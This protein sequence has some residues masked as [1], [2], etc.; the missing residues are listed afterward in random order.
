MVFPVPPDEGARL[1]A[2]RELS[3]L[4]TPPEEIYDDVVRLAA[5]I[6][7]TPFAIIN[8]VD[9][10]RQ[11]G[12]ALVG[13]ASSEAPRE[14]SFC[15]RTIVS[16]SGTLIV[17]DTHADPAWATN[18][19]VLGMPFLRF[20]AGASITDS[21]GHALGSVCVADQQPR[22]I[23]PEMVEALRILARQTAAHLQLRRNTMLL[24]QANDELRRHAT[25]DALT[26][27]ANRTLMHDRVAH[28]LATRLRTRRPLGLLFG[29]LDGF[30]LVNDRL[31]HVAGDSY[32]REVAA[33]LNGVARAQDTVA[34][35]S[36]DEFVVLCPEV[37]SEG[38]LR[39]IAERYRGAVGMPLEIAGAALRPQISLGWTLA[40][41]GDTADTLIGRADEAMY[42]T[43][44]AAAA[45]TV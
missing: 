23:T 13:L 28:A 15:A 36:G 41:D 34:R 14:A 9:E 20:Y 6:C 31:G 27:L 38:E 18:A 24:S 25:H 10:H 35:I 3:I 4:D 16:P 43:K 8:F 22:E 40:A 26:G 32:L 17:P 39:R 30:K 7:G 2:L 37:T 21:R 42:A 29:D 1:A 33:R 44:R 11:W 5:A 45:A 19:Q 12:K